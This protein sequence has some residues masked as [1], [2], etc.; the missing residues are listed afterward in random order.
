MVEIDLKDRKIL[1]Q[2]DL[3]CRQSNAQIGKKVGL[4]KEVVKYR[5]KRMENEGI[6]TFFWTMINTYKLGYNVFRIYI[7]FQDIGTKVKEDIIQYFVNC[8]D[9]WVVISLKGDID[10]DVIFW[11]KDSGEFYHF[12]NQTLV[13][14][15]KYFGQT[16][17]SSLNQV[18]TYKKTFLFDE[19]QTA[20]REFFRFASGG[21]TITIDE[22][23]YKL[24]NDLVVNARIPLTELAEKLGCS[25]QTIRYRI[26]NLMKNDIIKAF[27]V[28]VDVTKLDLE[29]FGLSIYLKDHSQ[30][31]AIFDYLA[32]Q[33]YLEYVDMAIGWADIQCEVIVKNMGHLLQ[34][35]EEINSRFPGAIRKQTF[36]VSVKYHKE[37]WLPKMEFK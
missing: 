29:K 14:F 22:L 5:I 18:I 13:K 15:G 1:Y 7:S 30:R 23:D 9:T 2:L 3:N 11:V 4:S 19:D 17:V 28:Y 24:L 25:S 6:I 32:Q 10:L 37:R 35:M 36:I 31:K 33:S 26:N 20:N 27:R 21:E 12:W 34:I 16:V 8:R